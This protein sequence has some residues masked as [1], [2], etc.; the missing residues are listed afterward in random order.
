MCEGLKHGWNIGLGRYVSGGGFY[1]L[2]FV[3]EE[4]FCSDLKYSGRDAI[5]GPVNYFVQLRVEY[6][7]VVEE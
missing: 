6:N 3:Y 5:H 4:F 1:D 2:P 7:W